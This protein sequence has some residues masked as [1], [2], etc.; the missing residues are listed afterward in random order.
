M[1]T[2]KDLKVS[3]AGKEILFGINLEVKA[4][5]M[6]RDP[7]RSLEIIKNGLIVSCLTFDEYRASGIGLEEKCPHGGIVSEDLMQP[8]LL[9]AE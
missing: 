3:V 6:S 9:R 8:E 4:A 5:L 7:I 1:L 2:I